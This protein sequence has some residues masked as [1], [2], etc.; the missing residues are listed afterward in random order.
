MKK[1]FITLCVIGLTLLIFGCATNEPSPEPTPTP[2]PVIEATPELAPAPEPELHPTPIPE[3]ED[4]WEGKRDHFGNIRPI[5]LDIFVTGEDYSHIYDFGLA[6][7]PGG[8]AKYLDMIF[9]DATEEN[10]YY[11]ILYIERIDQLSHM[12]DRG[13]ISH[14][15]VAVNLDEILMGQLLMSMDQFNTVFARYMQYINLIRSEFGDIGEEMPTRPPVE[16]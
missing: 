10:D 11:F 1:A 16:E 7:E 14:V 13:E 15:D 9:E 5:Y 3:P 4:P 12:F 8:S 6:L 2:E